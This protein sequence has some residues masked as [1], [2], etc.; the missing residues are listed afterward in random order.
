MNFNQHKIGIPSEKG[1]K[2]SQ[3]FYLILRIFALNSSNQNYTEFHGVKKEF[4]REKSSV[5]L[6]FFTP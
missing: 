5:K 1:G 3:T 6:I 4:H 2:K